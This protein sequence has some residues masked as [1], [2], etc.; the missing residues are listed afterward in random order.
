MIEVPEDAIRWEES[1]CFLLVASD[2]LWDGFKSN[3]DVCEFVV[4]LM[5]SCNQDVKLVTRKLV[6]QATKLNDDDVT[7]N[8]IVWRDRSLSE[9]EDDEE[10][11]EE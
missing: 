7:V 1:C 5:K 10:E 8:L 6:D 3:N 9:D 4:R 2:G 11:K